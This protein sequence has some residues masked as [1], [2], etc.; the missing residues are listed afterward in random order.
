MNVRTAIF[1]Q[2][3]LVVYIFPSLM[4]KLQGND[5]NRFVVGKRK[6]DPASSGQQKLI[7]L[8]T[9]VTLELITAER[10]PGQ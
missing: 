7:L 6:C 4:K 10:C 5:M 9:Q 2:S 8:L 1:I 3:A